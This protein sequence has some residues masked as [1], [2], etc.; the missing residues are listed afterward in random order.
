VTITRLAEVQAR[1]SSST[2]YI[3][4][5][6]CS[7]VLAGDPDLREHNVDADAQHSRLAAL[8][9]TARRR[10]CDETGTHSLTSFS[11]QSCGI[12]CAF[13]AAMQYAAAVNKPASGLRQV[14]TGQITKPTV[15][16]H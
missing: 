9:T 1:S 14:F 7:V 4:S 10:A 3:R 2:K 5:C 8:V 15:S 11:E 12:S 16:K 6:E 13:D